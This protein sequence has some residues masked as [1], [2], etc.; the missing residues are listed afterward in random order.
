MWLES[1]A[2]AKMSRRTRESFTVL[3]QYAIEK[4]K[5]KFGKGQ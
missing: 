1:K 3:K 2:I 4:R 5:Q